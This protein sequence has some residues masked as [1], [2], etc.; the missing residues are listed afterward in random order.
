VQAAE[1]SKRLT[2]ISLADGKSSDGLKE[3]VRDGLSNARK[4][5]PCRYFYDETGSAIFE[6][7]CELPEY[8]LTRAE[9]EI[10]RDRAA[11]VA[12]RFDGPTTVVE[13]GSGSSTKTRVLIEAFLQQH[14]ALK[15]V[16]LD[17]SK[18]ILEESALALLGDYPGLEV[19]AIAAEYGRGLARIRAEEKSRKLIVFLGSSIGNFWRKEA[20]IF[21]REVRATMGEKDRLLVG[22]DLRKNQDVLERAYDDADGVTARFNKN[23][24]SRINS[25]LDADFNID[26]FTHRAIARDD[27]GRVEMHLVSSKRQTV[28]IRALGLEV[29][30]EKDETIHT[31]NSYKYSESEIEDLAAAAELRTVAQWLD[32]A[33]QFS[34]NLFAPECSS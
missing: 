23:I 17:I 28:R 18:T 14:G 2:L 3:A 29:K 8:Y 33:G 24:L 12:R 27:L 19:I 10:L 32:T 26:H 13:L 5:L 20:A 34:L 4:T 1:H 16:P 22:I 30:F 15:Y 7:I 11:E 25:D 31:E 6:E 9:H 21:L